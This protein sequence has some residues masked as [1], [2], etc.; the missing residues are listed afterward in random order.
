[1]SEVLQD[2]RVQWV[3][4]KVCMALEI[5]PEDVDNHFYNSPEDCKVI[6]EYLS[7]KH[8]SGSSL[9]FAANSWAEDRECKTLLFV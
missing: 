8:G 1:M 3:R 6:I 2:D 9:I 7:A 4:Q 5:T